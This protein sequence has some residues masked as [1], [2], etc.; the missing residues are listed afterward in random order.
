MND[1]IT[2][3]KNYSGDHHL[4]NIDF[5]TTGKISLAL[6]KNFSDNAGAQVKITNDGKVMGSIYNSGDT[7]SLDIAFHEDGTFDGTYVDTKDGEIKVEIRGGVASLISGKIPA[8]G[9]T[10]TAD[11]HIIKLKMD[12]DQKLSG[13]LESK[14]PQNGYYKINVDKG[15][16]TGS[17]TCTGDNHKTTLELSSDGKWKASF[18]M[19]D[20]SSKLTIS[21]ENGSAGIK[22]QAGISLR[23]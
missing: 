5:D 6:I 17:V 11:H 4:G 9:V 8:T 10:V 15:I 12:G 14:D 22:A 19:E 13:F 18:S 7:H 23:F 2:G 3:S 16:V 1:A 21:A 20:A